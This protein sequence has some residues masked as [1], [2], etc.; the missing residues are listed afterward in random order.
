MGERGHRETRIARERTI[1]PDPSPETAGTEADV[2]SQPRDRYRALMEE[3]REIRAEMSEQSSY[4]HL[5][6]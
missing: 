6:Q 4:L 5:E 2:V 1:T 3:L